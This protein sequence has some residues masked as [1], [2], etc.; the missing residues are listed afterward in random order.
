MPTDRRGRNPESSKALAKLLGSLCCGLPCDGARWRAYELTY[1]LHKKSI[2]SEE[3][4][5]TSVSYNWSLEMET[6]VGGRH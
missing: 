3:R 5:P 4:K 6:T 1:K 2:M